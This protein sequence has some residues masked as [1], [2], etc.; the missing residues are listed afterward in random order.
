MRTARDIAS[1]IRNKGSA[2][3]DLVREIDELIRATPSSVEHWIL[4][5]NA[6][7]LGEG[8]PSYPLEEA[9]RSYREALRIDPFCADAAEEL[10]RFLWAVMNDPVSAE[11]FLVQAVANGGG[12]S[13]A[14][15]LRELRAERTDA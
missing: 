11:P 13:A 2:S 14:S 15:A 5:G 7:Q 3:M 4:R 10:G 1:A 12:E 6:I 8:H 9:E